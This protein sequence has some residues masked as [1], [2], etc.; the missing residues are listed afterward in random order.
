MA[1]K[2]R[3]IMAKVVKEHIERSPQTGEPIDGHQKRKAL[4]RR[5]LLELFTENQ[6]VKEKRQAKG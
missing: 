6:K 5:A 1:K 2:K 4:R 3:K